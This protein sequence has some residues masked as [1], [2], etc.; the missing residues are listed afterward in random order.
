M[1]AASTT[2]LLGGDRSLAYAHASFLPPQRPKRNR[3]AN[4]LRRWARALI[5]AASWSL[6]AASGEAEVSFHVRF[7][8]PPPPEIRIPTRPAKGYVWATGYYVWKT[9]QYLWVPGF[10]TISPRQNAVW[11]PVRSQYVE[12]LLLYAVVPG[13]WR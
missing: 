2:T 4:T 11:V 3:K 9:D 8:P 12:S 1:S 7:P 6:A 13:Y 10:W 5:T